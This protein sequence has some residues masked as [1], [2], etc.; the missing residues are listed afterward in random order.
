MDQNAPAAV[1][2]SCWFISPPPPFF[3]LF[4]F[5]LKDVICK[6]GIIY[7]FGVWGFFIPDCMYCKEDLYIQL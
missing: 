6:M 7:G 4:V 1:S 2:Q 5:S 3:F